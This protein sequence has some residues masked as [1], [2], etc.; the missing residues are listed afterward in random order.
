MLELFLLRKLKRDLE[1]LGLPYKEVVL[2]IR[3]FSKTYYGRYYPS[4]TKP[5][6]YL[7]PY[8]NKCGALDNYDLIL[9]TVIHELVHHIQYTDPNFDR[10]KGV[11]HDA[12]FWEIY[13][14]YIGKAKAFSKI[15]EDFNSEN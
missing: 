14:Y 1:D 10:I 4:D 3:P 12:K 6:I 7:Y 11:M 9:S 13:N 8:A 2:V 15:S 5:K